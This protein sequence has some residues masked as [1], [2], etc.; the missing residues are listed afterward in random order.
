MSECEDELR[1]AARR[2]LAAHDAL[3]AW[4]NRPPGA[5]SE[6]SAAVLE[7]HAKTLREI[8]EGL[9]ALRERYGDRTDIVDALAVNA[10]Y[11]ADLGLQIVDVA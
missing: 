10:A 8:R 11:H 5:L 9:Q 3:E 7:A 6:S 2:G 4:L 1:A